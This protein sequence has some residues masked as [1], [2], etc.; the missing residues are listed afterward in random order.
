MLYQKRYH[1]KTEIGFAIGIDKVCTDLNRKKPDQFKV[2]YVGNL[3]Y[4]KGVHL[5]LKSFDNFNIKIPKNDSVFALIGDGPD[6]NWLKNQC[7]VL[8][9]KEQIKWLGKMD[10]LELLEV[11]KEYDV[12][13]FPSLHDS[14]GMVVLEALANGLPVICLNIGGPG[15]IITESCGISVNVDG[16]SEDQVILELSEG[17][18]KY[19]KDKDKLRMDSKQAIKRAEGFVWENLV[20]DVYK[21]LSYKK[22]LAAMRV[23][24]IHNYYQQSGGEDNVVAQEMMLLKKYGLDVQLYSVHNDKIKQKGKLGK[25]KLAVEGRM[26]IYRI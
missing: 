10:R 16:K 20:K 26:V 24:F 9:S 4:W 12:L 3:L 5:A 11:Y 2:L 18:S 15:T 21:S 8:E 17:L 13:L 23:L 7:Q 19:Y 1:S 6:K 22:R 14:G 25:A